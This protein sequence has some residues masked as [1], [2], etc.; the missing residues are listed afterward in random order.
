MIKHKKSLLGVLI[1]AVTGYLYYSFVGCSSG[2]CLI[3]SNPFIMVPYAALLGYLFAGMFT[4][5]ET[6]SKNS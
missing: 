3:A 4:K 6:E 2:S 5:K 1:G